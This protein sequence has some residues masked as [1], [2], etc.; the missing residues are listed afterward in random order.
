MKIIRVISILCI[1]L[2]LSGQSSEDESLDAAFEKDVL[3][4]T[5]S[6]HACY[7]FDIYVATTRAQQTRGLMH[8]RYMPDSTGMLFVYQQ[9]R[10]LSMWMKNTYMS[11]DMLF[12]RADGSIANIET[13]T[14]PLSLE[15]IS[16]I[17]PLNFVL[18]LNA[19]VTERLGIDTDS[20]V[21]FPGS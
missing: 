7:K 2:I 9:P 12:I 16:A 15:T 10:L 6:E 14:D 8:V 19:G 21:H 5:A 13:H 3:V 17:E 11:L 18:E 20:R 1:G 4:I